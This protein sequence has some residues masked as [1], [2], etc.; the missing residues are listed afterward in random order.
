MTSVFARYASRPRFVFA[1]TPLHR[2]DRL[3]EALGG[4]DRVPELWIK[5]DDLTGLAG[6]GNKARKLEFLIGEALDAGADTVVTSGAVQSNHA[7]Q[8]A[9]AA[10][11]A[12][13]RAHLVLE[14]PEGA[15]ELYLSNGNA[16]LDDLL[17]ADVTLVPAN[18][19]AGVVADQV[20]ADLRAAG[21]TPVLIPVGGSSPTGALGY[22]EAFSELV[23]QGAEFDALVVASGSAGTHAGLIAGAELLSHR[24]RVIGVT[25]SRSAD[26]QRP[27]VASLAQDVLRLID[28]DAQPEAQLV[29]QVERRIE[30]EDRFV[31]PGYG[32]PTDA[33]REAVRLFATTEGVLLDPVYTGKAAAGLIGLIREGA[34]ASDQRIVFLH[35]GGTPGL[36]AYRDAFTD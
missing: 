35:T 1:P 6:G 13:L 22:V 9:A 32:I 21:R 30:L 16:L 25:V 36:Y 34:F 29:E 23:Q 19:D 12:G 17:G 11:R 3:R 24:T 28:P 20:I 10:A 4:A 27:K 2:L 26:E 33:M 8:T 14:V 18:E 7:R 5:R 31:G 15:G